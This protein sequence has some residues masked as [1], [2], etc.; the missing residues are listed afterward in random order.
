MIS[1]CSHHLGTLFDDRRYFLLYTYLKAVRH[2]LSREDKPAGAT[3]EI[4]R[5]NIFL[6]K[7]AARC[8]SSLKRS[9]MMGLIIWKDGVDDAA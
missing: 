3:A 8:E 7:A 1:Y 5:Y 6:S 2:T 9:L 4:P